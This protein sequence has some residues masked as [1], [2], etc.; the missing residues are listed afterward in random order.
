M[1]EYA[2]DSIFRP[3]QASDYSRKPL[4]IV[5]SLLHIG[6]DDETQDMSGETIAPEVYS[7]TC[8][9]PDLKQQHPSEY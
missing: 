9:K 3:K 8:S 4:T 2:V 6:P 7:P 1:K 5:E